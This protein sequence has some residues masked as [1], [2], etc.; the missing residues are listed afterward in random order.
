MGQRFKIRRIPGLYY[1]ADNLECIA[2]HRR[3][4]GSKPGRG[5][6]FYM[7]NEQAPGWA[8]HRRWNFG[9]FCVHHVGPGKATDDEGWHVTFARL[10]F[11]KIYRGFAVQWNWADTYKAS[12][13]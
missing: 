1:S 11:P 7:Y 2:G 8:L 3:L 13:P 6:Q 9:F 12:R 5:W 4:F 10:T